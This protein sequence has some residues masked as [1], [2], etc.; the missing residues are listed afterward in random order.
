MSMNNM[1][2]NNMN[3]NMNINNMGMNNNQLFQNNLNFMNQMKR[4]NN[5]ANLMDMQMMNMQMMNMNMMNMMNMNMDET[6]EITNIQEAN[7]AIKDL[8]EENSYLKDKL[9]RIEEKL[10]NLQ[11]YKIQMDLNCYYNQFDIDAYKLDNIFNSLDSDIIKEKGE[12]GLIN[13]GIRKLFN[14]NIKNFELVFKKDENGFN[15]L[16]FRT[17]LNNLTYSV[18]IV[19]TTVRN[20]NKKF[21]VFINQ[22]FDNNNQMTNQNNQMQYNQNFNNQMQMT[23]NDLTEETIFNSNS[24]QNKFFVFSFNNFDIYFKKDVNKLIPNFSIIYNKKF[25]RFLGVETQINGYNKMNPI[26]KLSGEYEFI[27]NFLELY[28]IKI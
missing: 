11:K 2:M 9:N 15:P 3:M 25:N 22:N 24:I 4:M 18:L 7:K 13:K 20:N 8:R 1:N 14:R 27:I 6:K 5:N 23:N 19:S 21:G 26:Y 28:E 17:N 12:F 10:K 16:T